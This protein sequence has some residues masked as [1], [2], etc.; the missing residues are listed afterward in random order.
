[1]KIKSVSCE[2]FAGLRD[3]KID[4]GDGINIIVGDNEAGKT[5]VAGLIY[6]LLMRDVKLE[7]RSQSDRAF[8]K[9]YFPAERTDGPSGDT[10][11]GKIRF[12]TDKGEYVLEKEWS[13]SGKGTSRLRTPNGSI[14]KEADGINAEMSAVLGYGESIYDYVVFASQKEQDAAVRE[15]LGARND[16][17]GK[18]EDL[19]RDLSATVTK[20][21]EEIGDISLD[22]FEEELQNEIDEYSGHWDFSA[23]RP[24][25]KK[26]GGRYTR[27][28]GKILEKYY[29]L[30]DLRQERREAEEKEQAYSDAEKAYSNAKEASERA[31]QESE[32]FSDIAAKISGRKTKLSLRDQYEQELD[33]EA[34]ALRQWPGTAEKL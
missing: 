25:Y 3:K 2:Q 24:E 7:K 22:A 13:V 12:E 29:V 17:S 9:S 28:K 10:I 19:R 1:M 26:G 14:I 11:D 15:I 31:S 4:F 20:A 27:D 30:D 16:D 34:K 32:K 18:N 23:D 8:Q 5:T 21:V 33:R 6:S